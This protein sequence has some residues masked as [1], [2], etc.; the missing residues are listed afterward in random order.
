MKRL[1]KW[2]A[3][4]LLIFVVF[5]SG[6]LMLLITHDLNDLKPIIEQAAKDATGRKL[7]IQ[8]NIYVKIGWPPGICITDVTLGNAHWSDKPHMLHIGE[9]EVDIEIL[10]LIHK[11]VNIKQL[12]LNDFNLSI[13]INKQ[14]HSNL[15]FET[16]S[17]K[18]ADTVEPSDKAQTSDVIEIPQLGFH[19]LCLNHIHLSYENANEPGQYSITLNQI[20]AESKGLDTPIFLDI[21]GEYRKNQFNI[22]AEVGSLN[23]LLSSQEEWPLTVTAQGAGMDLSATGNIQ[24]VLA[25]NGIYVQMLCKG[26][27]FKDFQK[28]MGTAIPLDGP[29][30]FK[31][32]LM[33]KKKRQF[34]SAVDISLGNNQILGMGELLL[35]RERPG[36]KLVFEA[37]TIDLRPFITNTSSSKQT[38][39]PEQDRFFSNQVLLSNPLSNI[40]FIGTF[41]I[42][43]LM[44]KRISIH[45]INTQVR[46]LSNTL[47]I[48]PFHANIGGG[49]IGAQLKIKRDQQF[50]I[51]TNIITQD[52]N[53]GQMLKELD[54]SEMFDGVLD[55]RIH[56]KTQGESL[57]QWMSYLDG[58]VS[59]QM[60]HGKLYN[61]YVN[62]LGGELSSN[63]FRL[64]NPMKKNQYSHINCMATR[65]DIT[66]GH[67]DTTIMMLDTDQMRLIGKGHIA[68]DTETLDI[69]IRPLPKSGLDTGRLGKY[70]LSLN[71]LAQPFKLG[72]TLKK[73]QLKLDYKKAAWTIGKTV[74]GVVLFGPIGIAAGLIS[75]VADNNNPC[76]I[77]KSVARTGKYPKGY[78]ANKSLM[79]QTKDSVQKGINDVGKSIGNTFKKIWGSD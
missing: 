70:S 61:Q 53:V 78:H 26:K 73:P 45:H 50:N 37:N 59:V 30:H 32:G 11:I 57:S 48:S 71:Q 76:E 67:A 33:E 65:F 55:F 72:G 3:L 7:I 8:G 36:L 42:Q 12:T 25:F 24:D 20:N 5:V 6:I 64:V 74:G 41:R 34:Q 47:E 17:D 13:E 77:A 1:S 23:R 27:Q 40:D 29:Y 2:I 60:E 49:K 19:N 75:G 58:Y 63:L 39:T 43:K 44:T 46:L 22:Q 9:L 79:Q 31:V 21:M 51:F 56:L 68:L 16:G 15:E 38:S 66:D 35:N 14:G 52:M 69:S 54:I 10:P 18:Q 28:M 62:M 4:F